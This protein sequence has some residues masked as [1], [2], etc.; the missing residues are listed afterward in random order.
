MYVPNPAW[1]IAAATDCGSCC[2]QLGEALHCRYLPRVILIIKYPYRYRKTLVNLSQ[3]VVL[4]VIVMTRRWYCCGHTIWTSKFWQHSE[5]CLRLALHTHGH[6][7]TPPSPC[8]ID[9]DTAPQ[10][11]REACKAAARLHSL[12]RWAVNS[13][14]RRRRTSP[15]PAGPKFFHPRRCSRCNHSSGSRADCPEYRRPGW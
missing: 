4:S 10:Q 5:R 12:A 8:K 15:S 1:P 13:T 2:V 3:S 6:T 7:W 11:Q 14:S 9:D